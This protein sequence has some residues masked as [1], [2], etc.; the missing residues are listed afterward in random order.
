M[1][2]GGHD[3]TNLHLP[4][5]EH[6][7]RR[8]KVKDIQE[9]A[10]RNFEQDLFVSPSGNL[11]YVEPRLSAVSQETVSPTDTEIPFTSL[12]EIVEHSGS[13]IIS[14]PPEYGG[15]S[16]S[17]RLAFEF[18]RAGIL[19]ELRDAVDLPNYRAK[20]RTEFSEIKPQ[21]QSIRVLILDK[22]SFYSNEK[23]I[24]EIQSLGLF[25]R[26]IVLTT[27]RGLDI[28]VSSPFIGD[29]QANVLFLWAMSRAGIREM[30]SAL[31]DS[32]DVNYISSVVDKVYGDL[33]ALSIPL[34]P[35]NVVMYLK[36]LDKEHDFHPFNRTDI[37][38][39]YL[40]SALSGASELLVD[41]FTSREKIDILS[42]FSYTLFYV[43]S[44]IFSTKTGS[45]FATNIWRISYRRFQRV[46]CSRVSRRAEF[47][48]ATRNGYI[49]NTASF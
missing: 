23:L 43:R 8:E 15:T 28:D 44:D 30:A 17:K 35:S 38:H 11:L 20:L 19:V 1:D 47:W 12:Q 25:S 6:P 2:V 39:K 3:Q 48:S 26:F 18:T 27:K 7:E 32:A 14:V 16:L 34:T 37:V 49:S 46:I 41:T 10:R 29:K 21:E 33:L 31:L 22:F 40:T 24:I 4:I 42:E 5:L 9:V 13:Y 36:V 45:I